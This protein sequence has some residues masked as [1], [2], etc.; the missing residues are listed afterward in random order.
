MAEY[1]NEEF[2]FGSNAYANPVNKKE[3]EKI[4]KSPT[5]P[6]KIQQAAVTAVAP[7]VDAA[8]VEAPP[9]VAAPLPPLPTA[10]AGAPPAV[11]NP[12]QTADF[13]S[14]ALKGVGIPAGVGLATGIAGNYLL[15]KFRGNAPAG[16]A[17]PTVE[18]T[19]PIQAPLSR[20]EEIQLQRAEHQFEVD[21]AKAA[22]EAS[23]FEAEQRR[24]DEVH[25]KA[26]QEK[27]VRIAKQSAGKL[28]KAQSG[29]LAHPDS[30]LVMKSDE[31]AI[32]KAVDSDM[33]LNAIKKASP[34]PPAPVVET[35][36]AP[37]VDQ[38][39]TPEEVAAQQAT[40]QAPTPAAPEVVPEAAAPT[41]E[42]KAAAVPDEKVAATA[43]ETLKKRRSSEDVAAEK[44]VKP[45]KSFRNAMVTNLG[46]NEHPEEARKALSVLKEKVFGGEKVG[47]EK[48]KS[49]PG[50][51]WTKAKQY[52]LANPGE[53]DK[54]VVEYIQ[55]GAEKARAEASAKKSAQSAQGGFID[56]NAVGETGSKIAGAVKPVLNQTGALVG[57]EVKGAAAMLPFILAT[58]VRAQNAG[59]R[60]E[61]EQQLKTERNANRAAELKSELQKLDEDK[62]INA[63]KRRYVDRNIP[64]QLRPQ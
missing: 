5:T 15:N 7:P 53:F 63:M 55:K 1:S 48:G 16:S 12:A 32:V 10:S 34:T 19:A 22:R 28:Q 13:W 35:P 39:A 30:A 3:E 21:R 24:A 64:A 9:A 40:K 2:G 23:A 43:A 60:R 59:Y 38:W 37:Q 58:D 61:L 49:H 47:L 17:A 18:S 50:E 14:S 62:Y 11:E 29:Q 41:T 45:I 52:I 33:K 25:Q 42:S 51:N 27:D 36:P 31:N 8:S 57:S 54:P 6:A 56:V 20:L 46:G 4:A 26:L 44:A